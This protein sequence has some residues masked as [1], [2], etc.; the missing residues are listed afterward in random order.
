MTLGL[1]GMFLLL[2]FSIGTTQRTLAWVI[3]ALMLPSYWCSA[4]LRWPTTSTAAVGWC[5]M[6]LLAIPHAVAAHLGMRF[7]LRWTNGSPSGRE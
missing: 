1:Y 4:T 7:R 2:A 5:F 6:A 3:G